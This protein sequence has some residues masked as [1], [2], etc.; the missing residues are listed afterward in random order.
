VLEPELFWRRVEGRGQQTTLTLRHRYDSRNLLLSTSNGI[1]FD[2]LPQWDFIQRLQWAHKWDNDN[3][4]T[5]ETARL[6]RYE[7]SMGLEDTYFQVGWRHKWYQN[8]LYITLT[9]GVHYPQRLD[10]QSNPYFMITFDAYSR[11]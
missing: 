7:H 1:K 5:T 9:P 6:W 4:I 10:Y 8:W 2:N 3:I 11:H